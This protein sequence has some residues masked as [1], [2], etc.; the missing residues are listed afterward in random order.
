L[1]AHGDNTSSETMAFALLVLSLSQ[2]DCRIASWTRMD[3]W[4]P[5]RNAQ[6]SDCRWLCQ[7]M[8]PDCV[9]FVFS[10]Q[11]DGVCHTYRCHEEACVLRRWTDMHAWY[12]GA[13]PAKQ[14][15]CDWLCAHGPDREVCVRGVFDADAHH[16]MC[17][18][19]ACETS[20]P[21]PARSPRWR[22]AP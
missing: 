21:P 13:R 1:E 8:S 12:D 20:P 19:Y 22:E 15:D 2:L 5:H 11:H 16:G 18:L 14:S 17:T 9:D 6:A 3:A 10:P 4:Y 7:H